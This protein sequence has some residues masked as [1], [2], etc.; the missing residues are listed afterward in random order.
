VV[1]SLIDQSF[2][3][4]EIRICAVLHAAGKESGVAVVDELTTKDKSRPL[5]KEIVIFFI[6]IPFLR[7]Q[8][9]SPK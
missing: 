2:L 8:Q 6:T 1:S 9:K 3:I 5:I 4:L 7:C